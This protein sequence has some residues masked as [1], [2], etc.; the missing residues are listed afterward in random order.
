MIVDSASAL[1]DALNIIL[2]DVREDW[3]QEMWEDPDYCPSSWIKV[4]LDN[5]DVA[6]PEDSAKY[7]AI[8]YIA[9]S[10]N[11]K[12]IEDALIMVFDKWMRTR[13]AREYEKS[14][15]EKDSP[16]WTLILNQRK[17]VKRNEL[18]SET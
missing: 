14:L 11:S 12:L 16:F 3:T 2:E 10:S 7:K 13:A 9:R 5:L 18:C 1:A 17:E 15:V 6:F 8:D 4:S